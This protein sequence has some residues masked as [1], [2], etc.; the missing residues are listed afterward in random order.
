MDTIDKTLDSKSI[1]EGIFNQVNNIDVR[2]YNEK[3]TLP[4]ATHLTY[5]YRQDNHNIDFF[6]L[7]INVTDLL[8]DFKSSSS[9]EDVTRE[10]GDLLKENYKFLSGFPEFFPPDTKAVEYVKQYFA[11]EKDLYLFET[12]RLRDTLVDVGLYK[13]LE[14]DEVLVI[15]NKE[16]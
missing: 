15:K 5:A 11:D 16:S 12:I 4:Y 10:L 7:G 13:K 3:I 1:A 9:V 14:E 2:A 8:S 6:W